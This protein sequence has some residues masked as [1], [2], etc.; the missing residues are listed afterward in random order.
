MTNKEYDEMWQDFVTST[1][2]GTI[3]MIERMH[4]LLFYNGK[5]T[6]GNLDHIGFR[7]LLHDLECMFHAGV[8]AGVMDALRALRNEG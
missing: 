2:V 5:P 1:K 3:D 7:L 8:T 4:S 6:Y